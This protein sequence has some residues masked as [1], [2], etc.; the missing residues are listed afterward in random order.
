MSGPKRMSPL[1]VVFAMLKVLRGLVPFVVIFGVQV[2]ARGEITPAVYWIAGGALLLLLL[3]GVLEIFGWKRFTYEEES[4]RITIRKGLIQRSE[5]IIYYSR[6]HSVSQEQPLIQRLLGVVQLKIE[7]PGGSEGD[8]VL[9]VLPRREAE[10]LQRALNERAAADPAAGGPADAPDQDVRPAAGGPGATGAESFA[11]PDAQAPEA[12]PAEGGLPAPERPAAAAGRPRAAEPVLLYRLGPGRLFLAALTE[13]NLGLAVAF[14]AGIASFADDLLPDAWM[15]TIVT[16][17]QAYLTGIRAILI[18]AAASLLFAWMLSLVL[19]IVKFAGFSL[20]RDGERLSIRYG[21]LE[22]KQFLFD[23]ARVQAVTVR[24]GWLRQLLGYAHVEVN[25][26]SSS[27]EKET[28]ALHPFIPRSQIANL[29][30]RTVPQFAFAGAELRPPKRALW[31]YIRTGL[32]LTAIAAAALI[33]FFPHAGRW[34]LLLIP[35]ALGLDYWSFRSSGAALDGQRLTIV[36]RGIA[37]QTHCTLKRHIVAFHVGGSRWQR[38]GEML[39]VKAHLLGGSGGSSIGVARLK[40]ADAQ[41]LYE[42]YSRKR[43]E[44]LL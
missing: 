41:R 34:A 6:I 33:Y 32:I 28:P 3:S 27:S 16:N 12:G 42:W 18:I 23:P 15:N 1:Y 20:Y 38:N 17:A 14:V 29:L 24:E 40:Q 8:A 9:P 5:K 4:D 2:V 43:N 36:N 25:V 22:R 11:P 37:K 35:I 21:L 10:R 13:L 30:E 39:N 7:T 26:V 31:G 44:P 19:F